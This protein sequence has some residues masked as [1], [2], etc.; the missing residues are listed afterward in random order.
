MDSWALIPHLSNHGFYL[1]QG[2]NGRWQT[3]LTPEDVAAYE[4][5]AV[6]ELGEEC[7]HW[8]AN[9]GHLSEPVKSA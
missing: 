7:A 2:T 9:G 8:L 4:K 1:D 3:V 6:A 5:R